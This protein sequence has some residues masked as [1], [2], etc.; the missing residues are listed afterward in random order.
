MLCHIDG[1]MAIKYREL[2]RPDSQWRVNKTN[3]ELSDRINQPQIEMVSKWQW[4]GQ[5]D[6]VRRM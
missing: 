3:P 6:P 5:F 4:V 2:Q 1:A